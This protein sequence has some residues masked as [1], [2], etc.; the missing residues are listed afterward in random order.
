MGFGSE[1]MYKMKV[2]LTFT[3]ELLGTASSDPEIHSKF[4]ASKAPD[5]PTREQEIEALGVDEVIE[6]GTTVFPRMSDGTPILWAYQIKGFF[7]GA[8]GYM[9]TI[10]GTLSKDLKAY[11]K[12]IDGRIFVVGQGFETEKRDIILI[13]VNGDMGECQRPLRASTAQGERIALAHSESIP[14]GSWIE[15]TV[16]TPI[17]KDLDIVS[18]WLDYG[19]FAGIGQ[20]RNSGKGRFKWEKVTENINSSPQAATSRGTKEIISTT[21]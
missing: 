19:D 5:A 17:K 15:F 6:N 11:K 14:A 10:P 2:K 21:V 20:W 1:N 13:N 7:K 8:C 9:R 16:C 12:E 18:E 3:D 4:I